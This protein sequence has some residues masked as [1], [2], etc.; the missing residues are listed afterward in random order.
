[1]DNLI[2]EVG[3]FYK[4]RCGYKVIIYAIYPKK[5]RYTNIHG[6]FLLN[7]EWDIAGWFPNG[8]FY[9]YDGSDFDIVSEWE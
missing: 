7:N 5:E 3:K 1:M 2:I 4:T 6:A 8:N 9:N